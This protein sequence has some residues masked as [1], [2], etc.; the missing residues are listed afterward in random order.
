MPQL[1][2]IDNGDVPALAL[3]QPIVNDH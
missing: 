2:K 3:Q 1:V